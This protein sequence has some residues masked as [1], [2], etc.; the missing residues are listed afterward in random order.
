MAEGASSYLAAASRDGFL[1]SAHSEPCATEEASSYLT[2]ESEDGLTPSNSTEQQKA[3]SVSPQQPETSTN[4]F[5]P[6]DVSVAE[7][8]EISDG[9]EISST[10]VAD[11]SPTVVPG[12]GVPE[13]LGRA[14]KEAS[15]HLAERVMQGDVP[16]EADEIRSEIGSKILPPVV[17]SGPRTVVQ[18]TCVPL[19]PTNQRRILAEDIMPYPYPK[20][21]NHLDAAA[22]VKQFRSIWAVN[23][24]T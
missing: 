9:L 18:G 22:H 8:I 13:Q 14:V 1:R 5:V 19:I 11:G 7:E 20:Y 17:V 21:S 2:E 6:S 3:E 10:V 4:G 12:T 24:G 23:D 15:P 16:A